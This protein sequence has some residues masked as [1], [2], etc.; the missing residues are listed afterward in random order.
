MMEYGWPCP[1]EASYDGI[2]EYRCQDCGYR[3][4]RWSGKELKEGELERRYG[5]EPVR[6][7]TKEQAKLRARQSMSLKHK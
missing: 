6:F 1:P 3:V 2:S 4:G 7:G 5:G